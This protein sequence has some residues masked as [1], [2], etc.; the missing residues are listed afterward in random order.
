MNYSNFRLCTKNGNRVAVFARPISK[1]GTNTNE[2]TEIFILECSKHDTF[3]RKRAREVYEN[4]K[5]LNGAYYL[6]KQKGKYAS[7]ED[8]PPGHICVGE[9]IF[10]INKAHPEFVILP[11][12]CTQTNVYKYLRSFLKRFHPFSETAQSITKFIE[13]FIDFREDEGYYVEHKS[14]LKNWFI[15]V[16]KPAK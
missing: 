4:W 14:E 12:E 16:A 1:K 11:F 2:K 15:T 3:S 8:T 13:L 6:T 9:Q 10:K 5:G 7:D